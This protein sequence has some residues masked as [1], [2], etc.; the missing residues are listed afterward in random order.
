M[1]RQLQLPQ[2]GPKKRYA[3]SDSSV[4]GSPPAVSKPPELFDINVSQSLVVDP[5]LKERIQMDR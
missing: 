2:L 3:V 5:T 4:I 1:F